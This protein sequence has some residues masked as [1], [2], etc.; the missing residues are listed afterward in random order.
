MLCILCLRVHLLQALGAPPNSQV[1]RITCSSAKSRHSQSLQGNLAVDVFVPVVFFPP[2]PANLP[3]YA[4]GLRPPPHTVGTHRVQKTSCTSALRAACYEAKLQ[5]LPA[6]A[7][8]FYRIRHKPAELA[9]WKLERTIHTVAS[10]GRHD[11]S[12]A[13][14]GQR[15]HPCPQVASTTARR[16]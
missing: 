3:G 9:G 16:L 11:Y 5:T 12:M 1:S 15:R 4:A 6:R 2:L 8:Q 7:E 10:K 13:Q 14:G